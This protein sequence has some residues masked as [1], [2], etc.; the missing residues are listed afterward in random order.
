MKKFLLVISLISFF[1]LKA[2]NT[3]EKV[4]IGKYTYNIYTKCHFEYEVNKMNIDFFISI[5]NKEFHLGKNI[6]YK[7]IE[8]PCL[9]GIGKLRIDKKQN[10]ITN[11]YVNLDKDNLE[12]YDS[13]VYI[14][15]QKSDGSFYK[16]VVIEYKGGLAKK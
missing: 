1:N 4:K 7:V 2:Q 14:N 9:S 5:K 8:K 10:S 11:V 12:T 16:D 6:S 15:K 13:I 3:I